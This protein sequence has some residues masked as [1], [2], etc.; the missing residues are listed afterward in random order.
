[1][2]TQIYVLSRNKENNAYPCKP[3][4]YYIEVGFK[5]SK[6]YRHVSVMCFPFVRNASAT[7]LCERFLD[8]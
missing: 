4:F 2:S 8:E 5:R 7:Y 3:Q 1:M 6:L